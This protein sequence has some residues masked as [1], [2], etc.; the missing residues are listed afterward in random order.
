MGQVNFNFQDNDPV[1][2]DNLTSGEVKA[3]KTWQKSEE[4]TLEF[5]DGHDTGNPIYVRPTGNNENSNLPKMDTKNKSADSYK[6]ITSFAN[7]AKLNGALKNRG[8]ADLLAIVA[9]E[10][11]TLSVLE[12]QGQGVRF[13]RDFRRHES[14]IGVRGLPHPLRRRCGPWPPQQAGQVP[15]H[16]MQQLGGGARVKGKAAIAD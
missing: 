4:Y 16:G 7:G 2:M 8:K 3:V 1:V 12:S 5:H 9:N 10:W 15:V 6:L 11:A 13:R 14:F